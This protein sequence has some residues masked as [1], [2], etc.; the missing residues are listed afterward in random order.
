MVAGG[1]KRGW[2]TW[3]TAAVD[4]RVIA[5]APM[6]IYLLNIE[7]SFRHHYSAY[8]FYSPAVRDYENMK[9]MD[10]SGTPEYRALMKI[11]EPYEYRHRLTL[12]KFLINSTGDQFFLPDSS[13]FYFSDLI[14]PKYLRYVPNTDHSLRNSDAPETLLACYQAVLADSPLPKFSW[15]VEKNGSLRVKTDTP[16]K[17]VKLWQASNPDARNFT[18]YSLGPAW[19]SSPLPAN[20]DGE[21]IAA[22]AKPEKGWTAYFA[23]LTYAGNGVIPMKFTTEVRV[24]PDTLPHTYKQP[25]DKM[26]GFLWGR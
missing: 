8:G 1:S 22:I 15:T 24:T 19:K 16:A 10:W 14:G 12:P 26:K 3:T 4:K 6:V 11:E 23:E 7:P 5:I 20:G 17:E 13:Q 25:N 9:I 21:Y 18:L 2:T